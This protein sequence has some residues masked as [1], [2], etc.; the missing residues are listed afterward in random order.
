MYKN[1]I[2]LFA[3]LCALAVGA[4]AQGVPP[5]RIQTVDNSVGVTQPSIVKVTNGTLACSGR[6]CTLTV[7]GGSGS[8]GGSSGQVQYNDTGAFGGI[9]GFTTDGTNVTAGSGNLRATSPRFTTAILD[10]NGNEL[11]LLAATGSAVNEFTVANAATGNSPTLSATGGDS[12]VGLNFLVKGTGVYNFLAT[13]SGP[14]DVRL[15][16]DADNGTNYASIIAPAS[17]A[18]NR[19]LTLPDRTA[20]LATTSGSLT[21]GNCAEFDANGNLVDSGGTCGGGGGSPGGSSG[22]AQWNDGGAFAG[23]SGLTATSS[24][25]TIV[26]GVT[27]TFSRAGILYTGTQTT[28]NASVQVALLEGDRATPTANDEAYTSLR[29]SSDGGNQ[30]EV[31]RLTWAIPT[32]TDGAEN[33]RIDF[34]VMGAGSLAKELQLSSADLSPST[35][36]GL[37]LGTA[38]LQFSDLFLASGATINFANGNAVLTHSSGI[39]AVSTGDLRVTTAGTNSA[40]AVTVGGTQTLTSKT[41]TAS[42]NV[43]GGVT[44]TL[45]SDANGDIY[46]RASN[47]LTRLAIGSAGDCLKVNAGATA[48]EWS[49]SCG[50]GGSPAG[51]SGDYQINNGGSFGA[52]VLAQSSGLLTIAPTAASSGAATAFTYTQPAHT[53][54]TASTEATQV[55]WNY[56][57]NP[58]TWAAGT[59]ALQRF[60]QHRAPTVA[61]ASAST[62]TLCITADFESPTAGTNATLTKSVAIRANASNAAHVPLVANGATSQSG[63]IFE[64]QVNGTVVG[65]INSSGNVVAGGASTSAGVMTGIV[66]GFGGVWIAQSSPSLSNYA[67]L[68]DGA[69]NIFNATGSIIFRKNNTSAG[70]SS[71]SGITWSLRSNTDGATALVDAMK[72]QSGT[73]ATNDGYI[74]AMNSTGTP[75]AGFGGSFLFNLETTTTEDTNAAR[76]NWI[77]KDA[78]HASRTS[79][80]DFQDVYNAGALA[81]LARMTEGRF[82]LMRAGDAN[83]GTSELTSL[84]AASLYVKGNKFVIAYNNAGVITYI[85]IP[86]DGATTTW[87]QST[88]AP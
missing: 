68:Y 32:V 13:T 43:L 88:S 10:S 26:S 31:A 49:N 14:A 48:P 83:P 70:Q 6:V 46:Y 51:S 60:E 55:T 35:S 18:A 16:E 65:F 82:T 69:N 9:S 17:M 63:N 84:G 1:I 27:A 58:V 3:L 15:F 74:W 11:F 86:L 36:D 59:I 50:G 20:T 42:S 8:P 78:T 79:A 81:T 40:S 62:C 71:F 7:T 33:G 37:A 67:L 47:V 29:M 30:R 61:F 56:A 53:G 39:I 22:Q 25:V 80:I 57:A 34:S 76:L 87:T 66:G 12:N 73:S 24:T 77:W 21:N 54:Q 2:L 4:S 41:L 45:G 75:A 19:V 64:A 72:R 5:W 85:T 23:T 38:S 28:D 52:G 44:M